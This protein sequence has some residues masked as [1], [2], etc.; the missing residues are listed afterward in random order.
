MELET[1]ERV[2]YV[3][4][5][6]VPESQAAVHIYDAH[7]MG[8]V[9]V[10]E[11][12]R[13]FNHQYFL[14]RE[15]IDR[16]F[17]SMKYIQIQSD[18]TPQQVE[19]LCLEAYQRNKEHFSNYYLYQDLDTNKFRRQ[20]GNN[21]KKLN[22]Y[23]R[24]MEE[25]VRL[26]INVS[27]GP[28][29]IYKEVFELQKGQDWDKPTWII[30]VW[31]LSKTAKTLAH[32][33]QTGVNAV[34][35]SQRQIPARLLENKVKNR[36]RLHYHMANLEA[37][38]FGKNAL[39]LLL[40]ED[41]FVTEGTGSNFVMIKDNKIIVPEMRNMLR[42]SSMMYLLKEIIPSL[43]MH[44][45]QIVEKNFDVY[46]AL[47]ADEAMF[48]GT[49]V[50]LLPCN[51]VNGILLNGASKRFD[52]INPMGP[53]TAEIMQTWSERVSCNVLQQ[54]KFWAENTV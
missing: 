6:W 23:N 36:S 17:Q 54:V 11:M 2:T 42:G 38:K 29:S 16:L 25:E 46:D 14:L 32:F 1:K 47:E 50:N 49:F 28:L 35:T 30:N 48:T 5:Q 40:D 20:N 53:A 52:K 31:P 24:F 7:F 51:R 26:M 15:H 21:F 4:G 18:K 37:A 34:V 19:S 45:L 41:G 13:T 33:Y 8:G 43:R 10:F 44:K 9:A 39:A 12:M 22:A 3:S 27:P